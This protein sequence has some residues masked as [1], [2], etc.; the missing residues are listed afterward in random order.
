MKA[1]LTVL[2]LTLL[3]LWGNVQASG[4]SSSSGKS[5]EVKIVSSS[6]VKSFSTENGVAEDEFTYYPAS[7]LLNF[8]T[9]FFLRAIQSP[10]LATS[11]IHKPSQ[12]FILYR[13]LRN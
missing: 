9:I 12:A 6:F 11:F 4:Q 1:R 13:V 3:F 7:I 2:I 5:H 10:V 8:S